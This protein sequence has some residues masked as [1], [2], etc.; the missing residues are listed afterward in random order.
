MN[1]KLFLIAAILAIFTLLCGY[2]G[3][4][5]ATGGS[6]QIDQAEA[7]DNLNTWMPKIVI[8]LLVYIVGI[9]VLLTMQAFKPL[10]FYL[11]IRVAYFFSEKKDI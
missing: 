2:C 4:T 5:Y 8:C 10:F 3:Y 11:F 6:I 7:Q 1:K 9:W